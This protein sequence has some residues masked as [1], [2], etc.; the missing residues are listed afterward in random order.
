MRRVWSGEEAS[1]GHGKQAERPT[2]HNAD[3]EERGPI[4]VELALKQRDLIV[5]ENRIRP[6]EQIERDD[7]VRPRW[8]P[9]RH[10]VGSGGRR[11]RR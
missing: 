8:P 11:G 3:G 1:K 7:L 6:A 4:I 10:V 5:K 9:G 2:A